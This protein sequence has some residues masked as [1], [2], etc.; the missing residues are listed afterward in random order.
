V[1]LPDVLEHADA[2][3][4]VERFLAQVS[5]VPEFHADAVAEPKP[6]DPVLSI[7]HLLPAQTYPQRVDSEAPRGIDRQPA[8]TA[9]DI[10]QPLAGFQAQLAA[11]VPHLVLLRSV[12]VLLSGGK[13]SAGV[14][15][16]AVEPQGVELVAHV[17]VILDRGQVALA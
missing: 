5:V 8:P 12:E 9:S 1:A 11:D 16:V 4:L 10:E 2:D 3:D 17:I 14:L 6:G 7:R 15:Q 13:V